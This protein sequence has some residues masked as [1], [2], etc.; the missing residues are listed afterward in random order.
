MV[1]AKKMAGKELKYMVGAVV[2]VGLS[3]GLERL[4]KFCCET[5]TLVWPRSG[6]PRCLL[7]VWVCLLNTGGMLEPPHLTR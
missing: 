3:D 2:L 4:S 7:S 1:Q 6:L 5:A